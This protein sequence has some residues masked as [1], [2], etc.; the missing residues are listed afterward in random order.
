[1]DVWFAL[2]PLLLLL[3][4]EGALET[5]RAAF[6]AG[7]LAEASAFNFALV[8]LRVRV[9]GGGILGSFLALFLNV[10]NRRP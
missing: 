6:L 9:R 8:T 5:G 4:V 2:K 3:L 10:Q 7:F 1:M